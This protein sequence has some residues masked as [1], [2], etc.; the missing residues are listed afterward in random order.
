[1][2]TVRSPVMG[3]TDRVGKHEPQLP[4]GAQAQ[5]DTCYPASDPGG[6]LHQVFMTEYHRNIPHHPLRDT[7]YNTAH[8]DVGVANED[9]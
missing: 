5:A 3:G 9:Y 4:E 6:R 2:T 1:M 8:R 7:R